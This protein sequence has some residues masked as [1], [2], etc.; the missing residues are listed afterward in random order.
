MLEVAI[1][2]AMY[3]AAFTF[4]SYAKKAEAAKHEGHGISAAVAI[5]ASHPATID[6][7][8]EFVI[9]IL[10]YSGKVIPAH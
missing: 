3:G 6:A 10:V 2:F 5:F 7:V 8:K 1:F 4:H 9:H